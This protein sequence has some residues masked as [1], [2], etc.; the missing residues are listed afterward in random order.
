[1]AHGRKNLKAR[2]SVRRPVITVDIVIDGIISKERCQELLKWSSENDK[3]EWK[4]TIGASLLRQI[5]PKAD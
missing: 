5:L 4:R 2:V 1:M 3:L